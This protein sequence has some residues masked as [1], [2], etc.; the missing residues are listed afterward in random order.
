MP[1]AQGVQAACRSRSRSRGS[2]SAGRPPAGRPSTPRGACGPPV[3]PARG[4]NRRRLAR[5]SR[6]GIGIQPAPFPRRPAPER[7]PQDL[8]PGVSG[9][10]RPEGIPCP[11]REKRRGVNRQVHETIP[12]LSRDCQTADAEPLP[13][14]GDVTGRAPRFGRPSR[15]GREP[16]VGV[17][18]A[19]EERSRRSMMTRVSRLFVGEGQ[20]GGN[21]HVESG[22]DLWP[23]T[24]R[25]TI[26]GAVPHRGRHHR[27][28]P[29]SAAAFIIWRFHSVGILRFPRVALNRA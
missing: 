22:E 19:V 17:Y 28:L 6:P 8:V 25:T 14:V 5:S 12:G 2:R 24:G 16:S 3:L 1:A 27:G 7:A 11:D 10:A 15:R 13:A 21:S 20:G 9:P 23:G 4:N 26:T 18:E 29:P